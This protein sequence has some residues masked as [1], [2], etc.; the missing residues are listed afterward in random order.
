MVLAKRRELNIFHDYQL[1]MIFV[2]HRAV[3]DGVQVLFVA[4]CKE[5]HCLRIAL[6]CIKQ[7]FSVGVLT[8]AFQ[9]RP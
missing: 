5:E 8:N 3:H 7:T 6:W 2:K 9:N 1:V 4:F